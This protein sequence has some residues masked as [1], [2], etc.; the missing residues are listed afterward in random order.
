MR[1][2]DRAI[3]ALTSLADD[4]ADDPRVHA[5]LCDAIQKLRGRPCKPHWWRLPV[6]GDDALVCDECGRRLAFAT[7]TGDIRSSI[8]NGFERRHGEEAGAEFRSAFNKATSGPSLISQPDTFKVPSFDEQKARSRAL[9]FG[10]PVPAIKSELVPQEPLSVTIKS[11]LV[12]ATLSLAK[13]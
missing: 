12:D 2:E 11:E 10:T 3:E 9:R 4:L 5:V 8:A 7:M 13:N 1:S 6:P